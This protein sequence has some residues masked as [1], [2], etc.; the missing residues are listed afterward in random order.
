MKILRVSEGRRLALKDRWPGR[1][2]MDEELLTYVRG[3]IEEVRRRGDAALLDLTAKFD[4]VRLRAEQ[5]KVSREEIDEAY[6]RVSGEQLSAIKLA[7]ERVERFER[8]VLE[9]IGFEYEDELGVKVRWESRPIRSVG[10]YV[11]GGEAAYPS[12]V[13]MTVVPAKVA[14]VPR[15]VVCSPPKKGGGLNPL[16]LVA[17]DLCGADELYRVG[18]AQAIAALAYGTET[19]SPVDKIVGP[20]NRYVL[21][22]KSIVS[23]DVPIDH[24]AGPSEIMILADGG[25][26]P[27]YVAWDM[28]AQA[29]HGAD[30]VAILV[31]T[32]M[33][34]AEL[35]LEKITQL[36]ATIPNGDRVEAALEGRGLIL[37]ADG[38]DEAIRFINEFAPE[39]LEII[40]EG[41]H[42]IARRIDSAGLILIGDFTPASLSDY[43]LGTNHVL[44]TGGFGRVYS[45]LSALSFIK[46]VSVAEASEKALRELWAGIKVLAEGEG[47]PNHALSAGERLD[48][49]EKEGG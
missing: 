39:H 10:C 8:R 45:H 48:G 4:G 13:I 32:S 25:A 35:V 18:G 3:I 42:E 22:A 17:A 37:V 36:L 34:V 29:E 33:R 44:P 28:I 20:G 9:Q 38:L 40:A 14:G 5:L 26:H 41:A 46:Y 49:G 16:T 11:P 31:T 27:D 24:P 43:L 12:T 19:I 21:A 47:L 15:V 7:K 6:S 30:S 1:R 23:C 2:R